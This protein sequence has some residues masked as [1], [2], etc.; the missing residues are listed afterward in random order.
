MLCVLFYT[1]NKNQLKESWKIMNNFNIPSCKELLLGKYKFCGIK[2]CYKKRAL[3]G[4]SFLSKK[5]VKCALTML[6]L[7][8]TM[9]SKKKRI[10]PIF[11]T[12]TKDIVFY[13]KWV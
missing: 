13:E 12:F 8:I 10:F 3:K 11:C 6:L 9:V 7:H 5:N 2:Y 4:W 1:N